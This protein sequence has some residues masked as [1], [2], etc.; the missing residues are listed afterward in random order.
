MGVGVECWVVVVWIASIGSV[1]ARSGKAPVGLAR[2]GKGAIGIAVWVGRA[3]FVDGSGHRW[4]E[5]V[6]GV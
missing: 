4:G 6:D 2:V 1:D 5:V 3:G